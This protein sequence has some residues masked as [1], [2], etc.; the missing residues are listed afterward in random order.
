MLSGALILLSSYDSILLIEVDVTGV[1]TETGVAAETD[2]ATE[3]EIGVQHVAEQ[4]ADGCLMSM[5][6]DPPNWT[7]ESDKFWHLWGWVQGATTSEQA[8]DVTIFESLSE[9]AITSELAYELTFDLAS[10]AIIPY[11]IA[12]SPLRCYAYSLPHCAC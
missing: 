7:Q 9:S 8:F 1:A 2:V 6:W 12:Q 11:G 3:I 10:E 4:Q 5:S